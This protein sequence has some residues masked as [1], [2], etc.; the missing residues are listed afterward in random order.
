M[1][2]KCAVCGKEMDSSFHAVVDGFEVLNVYCPEHCPYCY[3]IEDPEE[4]YHQIGGDSLTDCG[5]V[6]MCSTC[7]EAGG[8]YHEGGCGGDE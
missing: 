2:M 8:C 7:I 3:F 1:K 6:E 5:N 4:Q